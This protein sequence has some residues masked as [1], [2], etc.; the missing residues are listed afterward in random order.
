MAIAENPNYILPYQIKAYVGL[1]TKQY[2]VTKQAL[3]VLMQL[4]VDKLERYQFL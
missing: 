4:D 1:L 3:D 2:D